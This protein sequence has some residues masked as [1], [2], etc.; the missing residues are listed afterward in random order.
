M[1]SK[2]RDLNFTP[3]V[4][5]AQVHFG[6]REPGSSSAPEELAEDRLSHME[7]AFIAERDGFYLATVSESG[8]PYVQYRGGPRG[9]LNAL[10]PQTLA[11]AD[12]RGNRQYISMGNLQAQPQVALFFMDYTQQRRLKLMATT[13]VVDAATRPDLLERLT[14]PAERA[15]VER[16]VL[17]HVVAFDWNCP[18]HIT[19]RFTAEE[20]QAINPEP[21]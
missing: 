11:Y 19:P 17:F 14:D 8:W 1:T 13:E 9:F 16:I 6:A 2:Y 4:Q 21:E 3:S 15:P 12:L 10:D 18:Q 20:W 5:A 7:A